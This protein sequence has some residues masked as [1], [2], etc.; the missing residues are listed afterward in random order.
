[1]ATGAIMIDWDGPRGFGSFAKSMHNFTPELRVALLRNLRAAGKLVQTEAKQKSAYSRE[2]PP[3]I[4]VAV[5][6]LRVSVQ[7]PRQGGGAG[8]GATNRQESPIRALEEFS[9]GGWQHPV[10]GNR[11]N[12]VVQASYPYLY[13]AVA[14]KWEEAYELV[15]EALGDA[16]DAVAGL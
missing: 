3:S 4:K 1:M 8:W 6:G 16:L 5:R 12:V 7:T 10:F 11:G 15:T 2:I 14:D 9:P 13:P